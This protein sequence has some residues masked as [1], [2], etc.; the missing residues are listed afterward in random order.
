MALHYTTDGDRT[1][2]TSDAAYDLGNTGTG[3]VLVYPT[4][5]TARQIIFNRANGLGAYFEMNWRADLA[6]DNFE[7]ARERDA[8]L[9]DIFAQANAA[10]FTH[11]GLNKW[12][13]VCA[14]FDTAGAAAAQRILIGDLDSPLAEPSAYA[15]QTA[16]S[17]TASTSWGTNDFHFG[18]LPSPTTRK[19]FGKI[20]WVGVW[21]VALTLSQM[22][23][24]QFNALKSPSPVN[25]TSN[26]IY[27]HLGSNGGGLQ[28]NLS[29]K[30]THGVVTGP[31]VAS[32][33]VVIER[34][35]PSRMRSVYSPPAGATVY[36]PRG[37]AAF[38]AV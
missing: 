18:G 3:M 37:N 24:E 6:G 38:G 20:A 19:F 28:F 10:N 21:N 29:G 2:F 17:G 4:S 23:E 16:G 22:I 13:F 9:N 15:T 26:V 36:L 32:D 34:P 33:P 8:G 12:I 7:F 35:R 5:D 1:A 27:S 31:T 25:R 30:G 14:V 11:Y